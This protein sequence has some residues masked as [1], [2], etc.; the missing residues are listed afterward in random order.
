MGGRVQ[1]VT[2]V[3]VHGGGGGG[4]GFWESFWQAVSVGSNKTNYDQLVLFRD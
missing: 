1:D 3:W 2:D 4:V